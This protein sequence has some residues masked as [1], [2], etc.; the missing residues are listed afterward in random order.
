M[1]AKNG[2]GDRRPSGSLSIGNIRPMIAD[3]APAD[4]PAMV[5]VRQRF[6]TDKVADATQA[7]GLQLAPFA[8]LDLRGKRIAVTAGSRGIK[9]MVEVLRA[10]IAQLRAWGAEPFVVPAMGSHGGATAE[11]QVAVLGKLGISEAAIGA[12]IRSSMAV[13]DLGTTASGVTVCCDELAYRSDGIVVCNRIK[14]HTAFKGDYE[15]GLVKMMIIGLGKHKGATALHQLGFAAFDR[16]LPEAGRFF[17]EKAPVL[18]GVGLVENAYGKIATVEAMTPGRIM[19]RERE[20]LRYA[21]SIMGRINLSAIDVLIV[22]EIG[23]DISGGGMDANVTGRPA[24]GL[25]GFDAPPIQRIIVR[26]L[27]AATAGSS[28]GLGLAD[29]TTRRCAEKID[30]AVTYTNAITALVLA[31]PK[32]PLIAESDRDA[33]FLALRT[34]GRTAGPTARIVQI[35]NTK[36][37]EDIRV[38]ENYLPEL[39]GRGDM[40]ACGPAL[41]F[42]FNDDG[43]MSPWPPA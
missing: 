35:R 26:D 39:A 20:L 9:G 14:P 5:P 10:V 31:P 7:V 21:K 34:I 30:L 17:L 36:D 29:F 16:A 41:P 12:P 19:E 13:V 22:D 23:K 27:T 42:R 6:A 15:S 38:S 4:L 32:I 28:M 8:A 18:F 33:L 24:S 43:D 3:G 25:S 40:T 37:L 11:G 1:P 2:T